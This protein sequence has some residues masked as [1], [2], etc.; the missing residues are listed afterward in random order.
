M[1]YELFRTFAGK[2]LKIEAFSIH[3]FIICNPDKPRTA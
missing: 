3:I 1:N 2:K